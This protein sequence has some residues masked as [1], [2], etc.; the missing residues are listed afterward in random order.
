MD[1]QRRRVTF[2]AMNDANSNSMEMMIDIISIFQKALE[3]IFDTVNACK[4]SQ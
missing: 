1:N 2:G 3:W 4:Y